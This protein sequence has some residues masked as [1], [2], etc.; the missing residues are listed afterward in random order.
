MIHPATSWLDVE[1]PVSEPSLP[2]IPMGTK[3]RKGNNARKHQQPSYFDLT[4]ATVG[5][6]MVL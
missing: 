5:T 2:D 4:S 6:L 1:L 3:G